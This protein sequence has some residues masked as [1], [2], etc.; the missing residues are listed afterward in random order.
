MAY[1]LTGPVAGLIADRTG[2]GSV[3]LIAAVAA[4]MGLAI[5]VYLRRIS[6]ATPH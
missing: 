1:G 3:F 5:A 2:Y 6:A 4:V